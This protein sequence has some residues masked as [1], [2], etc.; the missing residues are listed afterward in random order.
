MGYESL[1]GKGA[2]KALRKKT[3]RNENG[4]SR[5]RKYGTERSWRERNVGEDDRIAPSETSTARGQPPCSEDDSEASPPL[6]FLRIPRLF[7]CYLYVLRY[8]PY[9]PF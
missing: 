9:L 8:I 6:P 2:G 3:E 1:R 5:V 7:L 4:Q